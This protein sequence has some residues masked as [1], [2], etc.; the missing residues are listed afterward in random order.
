MPASG[1]PSARRAIISRIALGLGESRGD[2]W[3]QLREPVAGNVPAEVEADA[4]LPQF[5]HLV[6][7]FLVA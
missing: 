1:F 4:T 7:L 2:G 3:E 6:D 5:V